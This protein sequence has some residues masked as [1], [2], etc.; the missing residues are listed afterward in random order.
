MTRSLGRHAALTAILAISASLATV[1]PASATHVQCG[2]VVTQN[3]TL[4]SDL[5]NCPGD[6]IVI[7]TSGVTV[8]LAGHTVDGA[9]S[10]VGLSGS[11]VDGVTV[12]DGT[13]QQFQF[14]VR[15]EDSQGVRMDAVTA[16]SNDTGLSC[17]S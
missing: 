9:G 5:V 8:D 7:G 10:G 1:A 3:T 4:D 2:D 6:G 16:R 17:R 11:G 13:V 15:V 14:G 12:R